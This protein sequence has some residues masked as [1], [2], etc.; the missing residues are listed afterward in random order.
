MT[1]DGFHD[2]VPCSYVERAQH[3]TQEL[4]EEF[5]L[6]LNGVRLRTRASSV[7]TVSVNGKPVNN[8]EVDGPLHI[9]EITESITASA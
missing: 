8:K 9:D 7:F 6:E 2:C 1:E 5:G 4:L 3:V